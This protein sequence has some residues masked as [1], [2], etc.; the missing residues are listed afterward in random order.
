MKQFLR[1]CLVGTLGFA[2]DAG[3]LQLLLLTVATNPYTARIFSFLAAAS[4]TWICNRRYT[5][6]T[7]A[8]ASRAEWLRYLALMTLGALLNY[9]VYALCIATSAYARAQPWS[10]V[11]AGSVAALGMNF[12]LSRLLLRPAPA[13][14]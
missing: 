5:F 6:R 4:V 8:P 3:V 13:S 2:V 1:F 14:H 12:L 7:A 9:T 11:A 10:A